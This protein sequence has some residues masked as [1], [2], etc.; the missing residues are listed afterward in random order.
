MEQIL[1]HTHANRAEVNAQSDDFDQHKLQHSGED[2]VR[3]SDEDEDEPSHP[4]KQ[5]RLQIM[6]F[7]ATLT[8]P[9]HLRKRLNKSM[10][11]AHVRL[12]MFQ[13]VD[14]VDQEALLSWCMLMCN[15]MPA[16]MTRP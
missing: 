13:S 5:K 16:S 4:S 7:S 15:P 8:L 3:A 6:V 10:S 14:C 12:C 9:L 11:R 1:E 2:D